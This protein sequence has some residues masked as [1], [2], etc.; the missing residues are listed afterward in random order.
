MKV[1]IKNERKNHNYFCSVHI[2]WYGGEPIIGKNVIENLSTKIIEI[3]ERKNA[4]YNASIV[5]NGYLLN[6]NLIDIF[7]ELRIDDY[8]ITI[9]GPPSIHNKRRKLKYGDKDTF[10][11]IINN[12]K[13]LQDKDKIFNIRVNLDK[14]NQDH[15]DEL[16]DIFDLNGLEG[17]NVYFGHVKD[18]N[19]TCSSTGGS[20]FNNEEFSNFNYQ[21]Q[22]KLL[23]R[24]YQNKLSYPTVKSNYC[25][26][27]SVS[28]YVIDHKG[29]VY[30]C[31]N[32]V[33]NNDL[34]IGNI[35]TFDDIPD[36][37]YMNNVEY[38]LWS[39]FEFAKCTDC[40]ILPICMGGCSFKRSS[41]R[42]HVRYNRLVG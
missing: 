22:K 35:T 34:S 39:P 28:S 36:N 33:G 17:A 16:L 3:C 19:S 11:T 21:Y 14:N 30:K 27:D 23:S 6:E 41:S 32:D 18:Y 10:T 7:S 2:C 4:N 12:V 38:M 24:N 15:L 42:R 26:A 20:C 29:Y 13:L 31:W 5:T 37:Q 40:W 1:L 25:C 8:Q 9:D